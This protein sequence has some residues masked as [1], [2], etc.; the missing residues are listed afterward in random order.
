MPTC[1]N[2]QVSLYYE[3]FG[4]VSLPTLLLV[5]GL[6][7]QCISYSE[8]FCGLFVDQGFHVI[9]FDNRDVGLSSDAPEGYS[10]SDMGNDVLAILDD[11]DIASA[12]ADETIVRLDGASERHGE[13]MR[14]R[15][16]GAR[17]REAV[18]VK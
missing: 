7:S 4:D 5:N 14:C 18:G 1:S 17:K 9:R 11:L 10:L 13:G 16:I 2:G 3:T 6:S 12:R 8:E 15:A